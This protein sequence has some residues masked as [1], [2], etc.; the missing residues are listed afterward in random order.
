[1]AS[2][3]TGDFFPTFGF[4]KFIK[5]THKIFTVGDKSN[6]TYLIGVSK[7]LVKITTKLLTPSMLHTITNNVVI[8][9]LQSGLFT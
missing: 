5:K 8:T 7:P 9:T 6:A 3:L 1:M 2:L 4:G